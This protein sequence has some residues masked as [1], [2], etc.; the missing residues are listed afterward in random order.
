MWHRVEFLYK[1]T[2]T[3]WLTNYDLN[4]GFFMS[5]ADNPKNIP[6]FRV[7][8]LI[9]RYFSLSSKNWRTVYHFSPFM[10]SKCFKVL[11]SQKYITIITFWFNTK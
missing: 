8:H 11:G 1:T 5:K 2:N 10:I 6:N 7:V 4:S 3:V 9:S